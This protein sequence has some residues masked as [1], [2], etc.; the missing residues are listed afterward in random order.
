MKQS[1]CD[2]HDYEC[3]IS[4]RYQVGQSNA[5]LMRVKNLSYPPWLHHHRSMFYVSVRALDT[6]MQFV[7]PWRGKTRGQRISTDDATGYGSKKTC[8]LCGSNIG[9]IDQV[10]RFFHPRVLRG[11]VVHERARAIGNESDIAGNTVAAFSVGRHNRRG[12]TCAHG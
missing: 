3:G 9:R 11:S 6:R 8:D 7:S 5:S 12:H 10:G 1:R 2:L 4:V